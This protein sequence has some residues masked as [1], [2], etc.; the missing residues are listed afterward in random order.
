MEEV[1]EKMLQDNKKYEFSLMKPEETLELDNLRNYR[2]SE[3][4]NIL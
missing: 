2:N 3:N 1:N 4:Y